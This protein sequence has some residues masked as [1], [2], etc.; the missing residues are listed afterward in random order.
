MTD[1]QGAVG[2]EQLNKLKQFVRERAEWAEWYRQELSGINWLRCPAEPQ[3]GNHSWQAFV[4]WVDPAKS[5]VPRNELMDQLHSRGITTRP[6]THAVHELGA[7]WDYQANCSVASECA[8][9][10]MALPLH[11]QMTAQDYE[12]VV[13]ELKQIAASG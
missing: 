5:P 1:L 12:R 6:G 2:L 4:T 7:Y 13:G 3:H 8:A 11:N 9:Q 10:T